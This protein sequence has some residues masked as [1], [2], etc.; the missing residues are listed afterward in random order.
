[1]RILNIHQRLL[2]ASPERVG[3]LI[4][5]LAS[6]NDEVWSHGDWPRMKFDRP[7]GVGATG[8]HGPIRYF[9]EAYEPGRS[10]RFRFTGPKCF[11]GW[12]GLEVLEATTAHCVLEHR[13]EMRTHGWA[14]L[15]WPLLYQPLHDALTEDALS[16]AEAAIGQPPRHVPWSWRVGFLRGLAARTAPTPRATRRASHAA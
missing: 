4:D 11:D 14:V 12:H 1:M 16:L 6:P 7:L 2:H 8:G 5:K 13:I 3:A 9:V 15:S 10:I